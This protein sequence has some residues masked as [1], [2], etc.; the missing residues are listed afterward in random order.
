MRCRHR[1]LTFSEG[2]RRRPGR[3]GPPSRGRRGGSW[4]RWRSEAVMGEITYNPNGTI[5]T[6][7]CPYCGTT[8]DFAPGDTRITALCGGCGRTLFMLHGSFNIKR[9]TMGMRLG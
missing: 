6:F 1:P 5:R 9:A 2:T 7:L 3:P 8:F 4:A